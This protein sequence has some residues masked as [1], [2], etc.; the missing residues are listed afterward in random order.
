MGRTQAPGSP[1]SVPAIV[2]AGDLRAA[3]A[4]YG[5]SK[6]YLEIGGVSLVARTVATLQAVPEVG[7]VWVVGNADRLRGVLGHEAFREGTWS[8]ARALIEEIV[9]KDQFTEFMTS[10][11]YEHLD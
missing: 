11:G 4:I 1:M 9:L 8:R 6:A 5:E 7:E 10:V 2:A 3:K